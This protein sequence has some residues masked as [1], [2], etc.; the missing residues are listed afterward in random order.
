MDYPKY[1]FFGY[2]TSV[3]N[4]MERRRIKYNEKLY[5]EIGRFCVGMTGNHYPEHNDRYYEQCFY[6]LQEKFD[7][8]IITLDEYL[9]I[10]N[11]RI[12]FHANRKEDL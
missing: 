4:E 11:Q 8:G 3:V 6:N 10:R 9:P 2:V 1:F 7:R 5:K 12:E